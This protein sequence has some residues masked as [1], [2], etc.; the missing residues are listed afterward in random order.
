MLTIEYSAS[1]GGWGRARIV[2]TKDLALHPAAMV[3]HYGQQV[4][5]G[6]KAFSGPKESDILLFRPDMNI[7]RF[8]RS[9]ERLCIPKLD[10]KMF[11]D[12]MAQ[13]LELGPRMDTQ[14]ARN[15]L[16]YKTHCDCHGPPSWS[17][18]F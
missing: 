1:E 14:S 9:C 5:E 2:K 3:L 4:F 17:K 13:L 16:V 12:Q 18:T 7:A 8:N 10:P 15:V 6:L 11:M